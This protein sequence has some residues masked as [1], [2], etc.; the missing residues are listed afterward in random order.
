MGFYNISK[1]TGYAWFT[2]FWYALSCF[3]IL[4]LN[5]SSSA[6]SHEQSVYSVQNPD[7]Q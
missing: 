4:P 5:N 1:Q 7:T 6:C 2:P 3:L